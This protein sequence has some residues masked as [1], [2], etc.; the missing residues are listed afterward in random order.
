M[1]KYFI[2]IDK[3]NIHKITNTTNTIIFIF[4][5]ILCF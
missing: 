3:L 2:Y 5:Q 1:Y 4:F